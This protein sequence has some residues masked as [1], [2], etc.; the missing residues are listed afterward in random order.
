MSAN[1]SF[2]S[3]YVY[4]GRSYPRLTMKLYGELEG[5]LREYRRE[6]L[7]ATF[8]RQKIP[9]DLR[10]AQLREQEARHIVWTDVDEWLTTHDGATKA[11]RLSLRSEGLPLN[12]IDEL[13]GG[14][15]ILDA[16]VVARHVAGMIEVQQSPT[17]AEPSS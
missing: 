11:L 15:S 4:K 3:P 5:A 17:S 1:T 13:I 12:E 10:A 9:V 8:E 14:M 6:T 16:V 7:A 2:G